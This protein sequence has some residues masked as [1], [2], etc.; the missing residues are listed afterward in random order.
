MAGRYTLPISMFKPSITQGWKHLDR[1]QSCLGSIPISELQGFFFSSIY[2]TDV[3]IKWIECNIKYYIVVVLRFKNDYYWR[4]FWY[5]VSIISKSWIS[6]CTAADWCVGR[7]WGMDVGVGG[8]RGG[9]GVREP[10]NNFF[11]HDNYFGIPISNQKGLFSLFTRGRAASR[12]L[13]TTYC[14]MNL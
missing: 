5:Y 10:T 4:F 3:I 11:F 8:G 1:G 2:Y 13:P 7:R 12:F 9:G 14:S 6:F